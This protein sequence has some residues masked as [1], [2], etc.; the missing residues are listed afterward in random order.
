MARMDFPFP[1][2]LIEA[3]VFIYNS[4]RNRT[5]TSGLGLMLDIMAMVKAMRPMGIPSLRTLICIV[6]EL[7]LILAIQITNSNQ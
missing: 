4:S 1:H 3:Y 2:L 5:P 7:E 6:M